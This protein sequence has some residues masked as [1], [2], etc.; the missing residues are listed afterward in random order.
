MKVLELKG[1]RA[2][3]ALNG[4][5]ALLLGLKMLPAHIAESYESFYASFNDKT[6]KEKETLLREAVAFVQLGED[7][8]QAIVSFATDKN[9]VPY[10][11]VNVK[12]LSMKELFEIIIAVCMEIG[13]IKIDIVSEEEK[14]K[15]E[16]F[17]I[18][19]RLQYIK[20]PELTL[21]ELLNLAYLERIE[22][23]FLKSFA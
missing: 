12:S 9:G 19:V 10:S 11:S 18:N 2:L 13:R 15:L 6:E 1:Y 7:E 20:H 16:K 17:S 14:K 21:S 3:K 4:F 23:C 8:V 5:H 22:G